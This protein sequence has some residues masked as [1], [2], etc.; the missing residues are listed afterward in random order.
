MDNRQV[1][2][3]E[4][5]EVKFEMEIPQLLMIRRAPKNERS[6]FSRLFRPWPDKMLDDDLCGAELTIKIEVLFPD[7]TES[8]I[9]DTIQGKSR[10]PYKRLYVITPDGGFIVKGPPK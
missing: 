10:T 4:P 1:V 2:R 3:T 6:F 9:T 7:G 5:K 8:A